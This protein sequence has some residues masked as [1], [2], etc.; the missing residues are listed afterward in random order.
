MG[1]KVDNLTA[2]DAPQIYS[3]SG[4]G[5]LSSF[6]TLKHGLE[7]SEI[8]ESDLPNIPTA[9]WTVKVTKDS[10]Y[11]SYMILTFQSSSLVLSISE[12]VEEAVGTGF[13]TKDITTVAVQQM[14]EDTMIQV[15]QKGIRIITSTGQ[16]M[17]WDAPQHRSVVA[18]ACNNQQ[19]ALALSSGEIYYFE[20]DADGLLRQYDDTA[21][22]DSGVTC[23]GLA[24]VPEGRIRSDYLAVGCDNQ[25]VR[26]LSLDPETT[27]ENKSVQ[28]LSSRP[29]SLNI[30]SMADTASGGSTMYLHIGLWSGVYIRTVLDEV[31][32]DLSDS[33]T[34]FLGPKPV[35]LSQVTVQGQTAVLALSSRPWLG[36][37]DEL[38]SMF[39]LTPLDYHAI[40][41]GG[42]F[43]SESCPH[44]LVGIQDNHLRYVP[45]PFQSAFTEV[46][47]RL[48]PSEVLCIKVALPRALEKPQVAR[49]YEPCP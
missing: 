6:K 37:S 8:V 12:T 48:R 13:L 7:V 25:T 47:D 34:R 3:I 4:T 24:P 5:A 11:D 38:T 49:T 35:Q 36:Y 2:E 14:G 42:R 17:D 43:H 23:L 29:C 32:G 21:E 28:A 22:M 18:A 16:W 1:L 19:V 26:I 10:P 33:R 39:T 20:M 40:T 9:V 27:L 41:F 30:I 44:G 15:H 31:T 46:K 45:L